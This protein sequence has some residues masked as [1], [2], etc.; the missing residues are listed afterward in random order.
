MH[1][2]S[3]QRAVHTWRSRVASKVVTTIAT[4]ARRPPT[5]SMTDSQSD[6]RLLSA[7]VSHG[8]AAN[9]KTLT[10]LPAWFDDATIW[11]DLHALECDVT[12]LASLE[13]ADA[14]WRVTSTIVDQRRRLWSLVDSRW[15]LCW[16]AAVYVL[17]LCFL[18]ARAH[19][20]Y[21]FLRIPC[22]FSTCSRESKSFFL[23]LLKTACNLDFIKNSLICVQFLSDFCKLRENNTDFCHTFR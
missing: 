2:A 15:R 18:F 8:S 9:T 21:L 12:E 5:T 20:A 23:E 13:K 1:H 19:F 7:I 3:S 4:R 10:P 6:G 11:R 16:N 17:F 22:L 14:M